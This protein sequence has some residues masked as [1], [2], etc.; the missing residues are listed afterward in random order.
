MKTTN[1][2]MI[3]YANRLS[4]EIQKSKLST[5]MSFNKKY[6]HIWFYLEDEARFIEISKEIYTKKQN[7]KNFKLIIEALNS[8][9]KTLSEF[10]NFIKEQ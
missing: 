6:I 4:K 8:N 7:F 5:S 1:K 9:M 2:Q 3:I 10:D